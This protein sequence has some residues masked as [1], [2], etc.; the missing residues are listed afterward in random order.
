M[1]GKCIENTLKGKGSLTVPEMSLFAWQ[2][3]LWCSGSI[4]APIFRLLGASESIWGSWDRV[5]KLARQGFCFLVFWFVFVSE[6]S[7]SKKDMK[8]EFMFLS[9]QRNGSTASMPHGLTSVRTGPWKH[10]KED[11]REQRS[12]WKYSYP[13]R[14]LDQPSGLNDLTLSRPFN[15]F[16]PHTS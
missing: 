12:G 11:T 13:Q 9:E 10:I 6:Q 15:F 2:H 14:L 16:R 3:C 7:I 5:L 8:R 4:Q 1:S